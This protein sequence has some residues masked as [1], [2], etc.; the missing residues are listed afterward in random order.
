MMRLLR[1]FLILM[2]AL[3][4]SATSTSWSVAGTSGASNG[5]AGHHAL[6]AD[7]HP[8]G[9]SGGQHEHG[10]QK[11]A[12][13]AECVQADP[14]CA[15]KHKRIDLTSSCCAAACHTVIPAL[16][17]DMAVLVF[18]RTVDRPL[19]E[20]GLEEAPSTRL[21]RPPRSLDA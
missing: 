21:D 6:S 3:A 17:C 18:A 10:E 13:K 12:K 7:S 19:L 5:G 1:S 14:N 11:S 15:G 8:H 2:I 16:G 20:A 9:L 4:F